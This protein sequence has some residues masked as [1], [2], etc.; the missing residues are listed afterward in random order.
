VICTVLNVFFVQALSEHLKKELYPIVVNAL[1]PGYCYS[2]L[3]RQAPLLQTVMFWVTDVCFAMTTEEGSRGLVYAALGS[4][5]D[6]NKLR[7][8]IFHFLY[9]YDLM[10]LQGDMFPSIPP[11]KSAILY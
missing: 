9:T 10:N 8:T 1:N 7:G 4:L 3:R 2:N 5:E 11:R 6:E